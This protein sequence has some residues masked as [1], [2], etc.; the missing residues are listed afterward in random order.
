VAQFGT[1]IG[2][3]VM[4]VIS[5]TITQGSKY[6]DKAS[7]EALLLGYRAAFWAAF[8]WMIT[9]VLV[10]IFGLRKVGRVGLKDE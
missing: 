2:L 8:A 1:S 3:A 10:G 9:T 5:S 6:R 7:D 4:A